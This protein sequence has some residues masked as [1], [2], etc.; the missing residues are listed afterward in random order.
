MTAVFSRVGMNL[1]WMLFPHLSRPCMLSE[2]ELTQKAWAVQTLLIPKK[3]QLSDQPLDLDLHVDSIKLLFLQGHKCWKT[4]FTIFCSPTISS[5]FYL[6]KI[7]SCFVSLDLFSFSLCLSQHQNSA[8]MG[9]RNLR[10]L[11][12][13]TISRRSLPAY[14]IPFYIIYFFLSDVQRKI[15]FFFRFLSYCST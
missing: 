11:N 4:L 14:L 8:Q 3:D 10:A 13:R 15:I 5:P 1:P 2:K 7:I 6:V 9:H 12:Q